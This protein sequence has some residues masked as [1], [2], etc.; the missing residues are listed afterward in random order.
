M[1]STMWLAATAGMAL[2]AG[3]AQAQGPLAKRLAGFR[4]E[5]PSAVLLGRETILRDGQPAGYLTSGGFGPTV[6]APLGY[7]YVRDPRGLPD[8]A[9]LGASY[10]VV[11]AGETVPAQ[12]TLRPFHDPENTRIRV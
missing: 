8:A 5:D 12:I 10:E 3:M 7:G 1:R 4:L 2:V 9:L 6:G 11:V